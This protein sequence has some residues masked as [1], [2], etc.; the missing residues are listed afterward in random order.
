MTRIKSELCHMVSPKE[1][2]LAAEMVLIEVDTPSP[3]VVLIS[4]VKEMFI[5]HSRYCSQQ[6]KPIYCYPF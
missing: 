2:Q 3:F 4:E 6:K 5:F 1:M